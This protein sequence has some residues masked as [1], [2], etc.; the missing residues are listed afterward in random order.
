M[1]TAPP[2]TSSRNFCHQRFSLRSSW[3]QKTPNSIVAIDGMKF[4][5]T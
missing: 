2:S 5:V 4:N 1:Q 3:P